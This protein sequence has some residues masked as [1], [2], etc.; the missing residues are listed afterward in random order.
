MIIDPT[1]PRK[2][3]VLSDYPL[4]YISE[5]CPLLAFFYAIYAGHENA[6]YCDY[7]GPYFTKYCIEPFTKAGKP[8]PDYIQRVAALLTKLEEATEKRTKTVHPDGRDW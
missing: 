3:R 5:G 6:I 8:V 7:A 4:A 2:E 1:P